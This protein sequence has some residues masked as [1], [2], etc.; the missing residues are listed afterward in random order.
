MGY[1]PSAEQFQ[2]QSLFA[3]PA[4]QDK[5]THAARKI[6]GRETQSRGAHR[7]LRH[8]VLLPERGP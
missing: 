1:D 6:S 5:A 7:A 2:P 4:P 8:E 3:S